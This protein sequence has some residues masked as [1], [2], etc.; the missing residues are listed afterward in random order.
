MAFF[1]GW[2]GLGRFWAIVGGCLVIAAV[3]LHSL[4]PPRPPPAPKPAPVATAA[5]PSAAEK[6]RAPVASVRP[7][8]E[9]PDRPGRDTPGP[10]AAPDPALLEAVPGSKGEAMLPRVAPD[11]RKP[12]QLY[13]AGFDRTT[14][15]A[16][17]GLLLVGLG[18]NE[19]DSL[20]AVRTLPAAVTLGLSPYGAHLERIATAARMAG[21]E[22]VLSIPMEPAAFPLND[23]GPQALM[24]SLAPEMNQERLFWAL[25]APRDMSA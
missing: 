22:F 10:V 7:V 21:H 18:L 3:T 13:A 9:N 17:V 23:P 25:S 15:R 11:G 5:P 6:P 19:A 16:R 1:H 2:R 4:G 8:A 20:Y 24:T 14:M 12:M